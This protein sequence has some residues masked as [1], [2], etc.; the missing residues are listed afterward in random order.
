M[1]QA[2]KYQS[3]LAVAAYFTGLLENCGPLDGIDLIVPMPLHRRRLQERGFNQAVELARPLARKWALPIELAAVERCLDTQ[4]QA[5]LPW[6]ARRANLRGAFACHGKLAGGS[7]LVIDDVM[8]TG[9]TLDALAQVLRQN[10]AE[11]V[12]N[13][14]VARTLPPA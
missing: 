7:V 5:G 4:P 8:T 3:R 13:L 2:L 10:G 9:A 1:V 6:A 11:R 14:V 12:S